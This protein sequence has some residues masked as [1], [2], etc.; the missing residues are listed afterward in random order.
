MNTS[1]DYTQLFSSL[2]S[3]A[4][5]VA[6]SSFLSDWYSL[7]NGSTFKLYKA[8]YTENADSTTDTSSTTA[9][10]TDKTQGSSNSSAAASS[11]TSTSSDSTKTL[12][13]I[14]SSANELKE[15]AGALM[16]SALYE[17]SEVT[18]TNEDGTTTTTTNK[19]Q[20][21]IYSA[22]QSF[23]EDYNSLVKKE[24]DVQSTSVTRGIDRLTGSTEASKN[25]LSKIGI[26]INE[27]K[28]LSLDKDTFSKGKL[29]TVE[30]L[31][32]GSGSYGDQTASRAST[33]KL[34]AD[35]EASK[36][37]TYKETG[38]YADVNAA[39]SLFDSYL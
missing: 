33:L 13:A 19:A 21:K 1:L 22:L 2:G 7:R 14:Q 4:K 15:S 5:D 17:D 34:A 24:E 6:G 11:S 38:N 37:V 12:A 29:S 23:V 8:Y 9:T 26:T 30:T 35:R 3:G 16:E 31:F 10:D 28:T 27:D 20:D 25:L 18:T 32:K 36:A 39:G